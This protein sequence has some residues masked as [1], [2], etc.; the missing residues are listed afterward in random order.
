MYL[1]VCISEEGHLGAGF[2]LCRLGLW[3]MY[4]W[5]C[6][7]GEGHSGAGFTLRKRGMGPVAQNCRTA[8]RCFRGI[9]AKGGMNGQLG[10]SMAGPP[11]A[12][13]PGPVRSMK[14]S[15]CSASQA[16]SPGQAQL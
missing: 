3:A 9:L 4:L 13:V 7:S 15:L 10:R 8:S 1:W 12:A 16:L 5:V 2:T 6:I 11:T 14:N